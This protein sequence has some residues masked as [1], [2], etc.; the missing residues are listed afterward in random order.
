MKNGDGI[1]DTIY[2][3]GG[4]Q[5]LKLT[6]ENGKYGTHILTMLFFG[7]AASGMKKLLQKPQDP[8]MLTR[9]LPPDAF[10]RFKAPDYRLVD[11]FCLCFEPV[12]DLPQFAL[13]HKTSNLVG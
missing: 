9:N 1:R 6:G 5:P 12:L 10:R 8:D 4:D 11:I 3:G 7:A 13:A 2:G